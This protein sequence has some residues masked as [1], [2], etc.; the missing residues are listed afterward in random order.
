[1]TNN[2][3]VRI[4][5]VLALLA[6]AAGSA[7]QELTVSSA[8]TVQPPKIDGANKDWE[9]APLSAWEKGG[10]QYSFRND[11]AYLYVLFMIQDAK[12]RSSIEDVGI[13][14]YF[15]TS[16]GDNKDYGILFRRKRITANESIALL[17]QEGPVSDEQKAKIRQTSFYNYYFGEVVHKKVA[18][19]TVPPGETRPP[20]MFKYVSDRKSIVYEFAIPLHRAHPALAGVGAGLGAILSLGFEWGGPTEAQLK[21]LARSRGDRAKIANETESSVNR[22]ER[23]LSARDADRLP[24]KYSFW[25]KVSL[26]QKGV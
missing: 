3:I 9:G 22:M 16:G 24:L 23:T 1:M 2:S 18:P 14:L 21:A 11:D 13:T 25:T 10:V 6:L 4:G 7:G 12:L 5:G 19:G 17:E 15:D 26:A 8:W 20:A